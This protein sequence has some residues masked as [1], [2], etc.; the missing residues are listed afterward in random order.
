MGVQPFLI[1]STV[2]VVIAQRLVRRICSVCIHS[3]DV[4]PE[5]AVTLESQVAQMKQFF[6]D[7]DI[8]IKLPSRLYYGTGCKSC[9]Q[10]GYRGQ[11]AVF[12]V[13]RM[14]EGVRS[15]LLQQASTSD[16]R[17]Q[18]VK[19]GMVPMFQDGLRKVEEGITT[20]EEVLRV[21]RE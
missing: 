18:A 10:S 14:T 1:A 2:N 9:G 6:G 4:T 17:R 20:I 12:E 11:L 7:M 13:M 5:Q 21:A 8:T 19:D 15:L 3:K 16:I